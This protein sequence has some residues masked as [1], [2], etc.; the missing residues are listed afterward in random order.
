MI[1]LAR[2]GLILV[3]ALLLGSCG[4]TPSRN[5]LAYRP[6]CETPGHCPE[7]ESAR[8]WALARQAEQHAGRARFANAAAGHWLACS[9]H[10]YPGWHTQDPERMADAARLA[11]RC[12]EALLSIE[13]VRKG[14]RKGTD[15]KGDGGN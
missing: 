4:S 2:P 1:P 13:T 7:G 6:T 11:T 14:T 3:A 15:E 5:E 10:A 9:I 8:R 12:T